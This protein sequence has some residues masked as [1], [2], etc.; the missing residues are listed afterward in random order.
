MGEGCA[1][2]FLEALDIFLSA[3]PS[4]LSCSEAVNLANRSREPPAWRQAGS[5][6]GDL[7]DPFLSPD[8]ATNP[9]QALWAA[10]CA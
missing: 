1:A 5:G 8:P 2:R 4:Q 9:F 10:G 7:M 3:S 6:P